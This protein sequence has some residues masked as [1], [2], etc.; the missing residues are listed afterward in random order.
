M[1][2]IFAGMLILMCTGLMALVTP[3]P[4]MKEVPEFY[5]KNKERQNTN[6]FS[7]FN[8]NRSNGF[9][10]SKDLPDSVLVLMVQFQDI[11]FNLDAVHP[12]YLPHDRAFYERHMYHMADYYYD[13]SLGNYDLKNKDEFPDADCTYYI[14][15]TVFTLPE[16][17]SYYGD[18]DIW[19]ERI[20][21]FALHIVQAADQEVD[22]KDFDSIIIFHAGAGQEADLNQVNQDLLWSTFIS[23]SDLHEGLDPENENYCGIPSNDGVFLTEFVICP[24][25]EWQP[26]FS[27]EN[28][29]RVLSIFGVLAHQF[30]HRIGLPTL[31]DNVSSNGKS[32]GIGNFCIMGTGTWN[33]DGHVPPYLSAWLRYFMYWDE[34]VE[35]NG[36]TWNDLQI[37]DYLHENVD[38]PK[39]YKLNISE[40][41]FFLLENRQSN[42]DSSVGSAT[43]NPSF[44]FKLLPENEQDYYPPESPYA[45]EPR[46][47]FMTNSYRGCE[48]DFYMPGLGGP[49]VTVDSQYALIDGSGILIW[50]ID[51]NV[52]EETFNQDFSNNYPNGDARHKAVDL[53]EA[54]GIQHMDSQNHVFYR[55]GPYD[56]YRADNN[57][58]FGGKTAPDG[59]VSTPTAESYYGGIN[60]AIH[61][62]SNSAPIMTFSVDFGWSLNANYNG[63]N[64]QPMAMLDIDDDGQNEIFYPM[65]NGK[66][67]IWNNGEPDFT[68]T[69]EDKF[70][71]NILYSF[72]QINRQLYLPT[73]RTE[74]NSPVLHSLSYSEGFTEPVSRIWH[75]SYIWAASPVV[76]SDLESK[77][78]NKIA[79]AFNITE[80]ET[81]V[82]LMLDSSLNNTEI[83][84][85]F[86]SQRIASN[87]V[88]I[89]NSLFCIT[90]KNSELYLSNLNLQENSA[91]SMKIPKLLENEKPQYLVGFPDSDSDSDSDSDLLCLVGNAGSIQLFNTAA[92]MYPEFPVV[93]PMSS[94]SMPVLADID[95]NGII[96]VLLGGENEF[97]VLN[98]YGVD[99][100]IS[101]ESTDSLAVAS[102]ITS[103][104]LDSDGK[105][106][107][108]GNFSQ[109]RL[110]IWEENYTVKNDFPVTSRYRSRFLPVFDEMEDG[111]V[112]AL[113]ATDNGS[114]YRFNLPDANIG[115]VKKM[116]W[117]TEA[118]NLHRT[119]YYGKI[120]PENEYYTKSLF[121]KDEVYVYP[122][123]LNWING[124]NPKFS[125]MTSQNCKVDVKIYNISGNQVFKQRIQC[126]AY[127]RNEEK[128]NWDISSISSGIYFISFTSGGD[129]VVNKIAIEK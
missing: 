113:I 116:V 36:E 38:I 4:D 93:I 47:N 58:Y 99:K 74:T 19:S 20:S 37:A 16:N 24:E 14:W 40:K 50:H 104:D 72:D 118:G 109:N 92:E 13:S 7:A 8:L 85:L 54:D 117:R 1:K 22:F 107:F 25:T 82:V 65:T 69:S 83:D 31:F 46:F 3:H 97:V 10:N 63:T 30:G 128:I 101:I 70:I 57:T 94:I 59:S 102:G 77:S 75:N 9:R 56:S 108:I 23:V 51:E 105:S 122:N 87:L 125:I 78:D 42:P 123:P 12:D 95:Q 114:I 49:V 44:T 68:Y 48:W 2:K 53:E 84:S 129:S 120:L 110:F 66:L 127:S 64:T 88:K 28:N 32:S 73:V 81:S 86:L 61:N 29:D 103:L 80:S 71:E 26:D 5:Y 115:D 90:E 15:P 79:V 76:M 33:A 112:Y 21:A 41:E 119:A 60:L 39:M 27:M 45:G 124:L 11:A 91:F 100:H 126:D 52:F 35:L 67:C 98:R 111:Q 106:E 17:M 62:I 34:P 6:S 89:D 18:D 121:V 96:D 55:G 43:G